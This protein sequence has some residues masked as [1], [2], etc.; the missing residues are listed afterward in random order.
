[1]ERAEGMAGTLRVTTVWVL[2]R[3]TE[4]RMQQL[5]GV[6]HEENLTFLRR[7]S[8]KRTKAGAGLRNLTTTMGG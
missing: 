7:I 1:M 2:K 3:L 5:E 6:R 4:Q 8:R